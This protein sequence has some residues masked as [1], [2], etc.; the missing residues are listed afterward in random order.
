MG[1]LAVGLLLYGSGLRLMECLTL[2]VKDLDLER[3]ELT[4][5]RGKGRKDRVT[6]I[7]ETLR[8]ALR[9]PLERVRS[10]HLQDP[11]MGGMGRVCPAGWT[12]NIPMRRRHGPGSGCFQ[13][14][15]GTAIQ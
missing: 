4:V 13:P 12:P 14:G 5:R 6:V 2:R 3:G 15:E 8:G 11:T 7:P 1:G 9:E 10:L